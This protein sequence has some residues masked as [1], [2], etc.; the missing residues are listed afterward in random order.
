[1]PKLHL[2]VTKFIVPSGVM[3]EKDLIIS[4]M[5]FGRYLSNRSDSHLMGTLTS[6]EGNTYV[7]DIVRLWD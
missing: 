7:H 4:W 2:T 3:C 1:M 6:C 5:V